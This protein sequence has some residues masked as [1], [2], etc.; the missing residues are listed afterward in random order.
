MTYLGSARASPDEAVSFLS[1]RLSVGRI[2][3]RTG[4]DD[5]EAERKNRRVG[6]CL[7]R[8]A[9]CPIKIHNAAGTMGGIQTS[10]FV[11]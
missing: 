1:F 11:R 9:V 4:P 6:R 2:S 7:L 5:V 3:G 8:D 10:L